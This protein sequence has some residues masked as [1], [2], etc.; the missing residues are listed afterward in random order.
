MKY[1]SIQIQTNLDD[2]YSVDDAI[3]LSRKLGR[4]PEV[5][6]GDDKGKFIHL[7]YFSEDVARL[8][9]ELKTGMLDDAVL[10]P[11]LR[12][13]AVIVCEG[14]KGPDDYLLLWHWDASEEL[15]SL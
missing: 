11:W 2:S 13:V 1:L 12:N 10:G 8:W 9:S 5:D 7:N 6:S 15:D 14:D 3:D 4:F